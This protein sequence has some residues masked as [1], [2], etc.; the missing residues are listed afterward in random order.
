MHNETAAN[1]IFDSVLP[2]TSFV[3]RML[4]LTDHFRVNLHGFDAE[5]SPL[6]YSMYYARFKT[7]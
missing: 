3:L 7:D 1:T 6:T 2:E 5:M 4:E